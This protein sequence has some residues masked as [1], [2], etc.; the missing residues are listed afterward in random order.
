LFFIQLLDQF[1]R[2]PLRG[3]RLMTHK[4]ELGVLFCFAVLMIKPRVCHTTP[5][6]LSYIV[7]P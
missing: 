1:I 7:N 5:L 4:E 3:L 6:P 2:T